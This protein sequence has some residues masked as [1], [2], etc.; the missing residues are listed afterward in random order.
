MSLEP[1]SNQ[2]PRDFWEF[3]ITVPRSTNWA[4]K[5]GRVRVWKKKDKKWKPAFW[6]RIY[7]FIK[8]YGVKTQK[9]RTISEF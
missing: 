4:I 7:L 6:T 5:G 9:K 3:N 1:D 8:I 2:R